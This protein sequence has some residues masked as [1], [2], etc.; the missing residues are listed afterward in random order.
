MYQ[1]HSDLQ[2]SYPSQ[3]A[4]IKS[5]LVCNFWLYS[6]VCV[7][8]LLS[9]INLIRLGETS[10]SAL[11]PWFIGFSLVAAIKSRRVLNQLALPDLGGPSFKKGVRGLMCLNWV[12]IVI[13]LI[14]FASILIYLALVNAGDKTSSNQKRV[15]LIVAIAVVLHLF[16]FFYQVARHKNLRGCLLELQLESSGALDADQAS[17]TDDQVKNGPRYGF[18]E[19]P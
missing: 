5:Y 17:L 6:V 3:R 8:H 10:K 16:P 2:L 15:W 1:R 18:A 19:H 7:L 9:V 13:N 4:T 11:N 14:G 12:A